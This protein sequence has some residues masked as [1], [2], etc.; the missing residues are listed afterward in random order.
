MLLFNLFFQ[1]YFLNINSSDFFVIFIIK[2]YMYGSVEQLSYYKYKAIFNS[3]SSTNLQIKE[4]H[5]FFS[6]QIFFFVIFAIS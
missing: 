1:L 2:S 3:L 4:N 5:L 6:S